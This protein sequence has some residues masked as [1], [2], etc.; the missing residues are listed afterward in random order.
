[1]RS[2]HQTGRAA[3][4]FATESAVACMGGFLVTVAVA[5]NQRWLDR[6]FLPNFF[7]SRHLY[8]LLESAIRVAI[9]ALGAALALLARRPIGRFVAHNPQTA[10]SVTVAV[11]LAFGA[12]ELILRRLDLRAAM[13]EPTR[14]EPGR[15]RDPQLGWSFVPLRT[16][17]HS[18]GGRV[19]EYAFDSSGYR[20]RR[21]EEAVDPERPT[22]LFTGESMMVGEGLTWDET[23]PAQ[24]GAMLGLQSANLAVS[25]FASDQAY[26][27][28]Q[29]ELPRFRRPVAVVL[30]FTPAIFDRNLDDD[31]PH[32]GPG[33]VWLPAEHRW[34]LATI[35]KLLVPYRS[36]ETIERGISLTRE[37][38]RATVELARS[39][40]AVPLIVVPEF[41][42]E[43][44]GEQA[45]RH[46]ILDDTG[47]PYVRVE[48]DPTWRISD[49]DHPDPRAARAIADGVAARLRS[50]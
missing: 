27:R 7:L 19:V 16:G 14:I 10:L 2:E 37:V 21:V 38:L 26:L 47:L 28:L 43:E 9:G 34:R 50:R 12:S 48:L 1:L 4:R 6:H 13:E 24:T 20:V 23:I 25:G 11:I 36:S 49:D 46:Q 42:P 18:I 30:L 17:R 3:A 33:L 39:R 15:R 32:L 5:A 45:L 8:V 29:N 22:I 35:A 44:P 31:R 40:G 41:G